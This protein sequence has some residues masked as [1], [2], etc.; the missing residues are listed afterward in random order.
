MLLSLVAILMNWGLVGLLHDFDYERYP[1]VAVE[2][3]PVI[4][5]KILRE[6]GMPEDIIKAILA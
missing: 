2:G 5:S 3:H 1:D 6:R 4:G